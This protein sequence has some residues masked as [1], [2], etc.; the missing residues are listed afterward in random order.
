LFGDSSGIDLEQEMKDIE[1]CELR[2][3]PLFVARY[4]LSESVWPGT[5]PLGRNV[6]E[7]VG[8]LDP[9]RV[10][11]YL[12]ER[13][14]PLGAAYIKIIEREDRKDSISSKIWGFII[15]LL[16]FLSLFPIH[17]MLAPK[18]T[19]LKV[20]AG[21]FFLVT[22]ASLV[23]L[24]LIQVVIFVP[25]NYVIFPNRHFGPEHLIAVTICLI[26]SMLCLKIWSYYKMTT[27]LK[28]VHKRS[29]LRTFSSILVGDVVSILIGF[30]LADLLNTAL[31]LLNI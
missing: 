1:N 25:W 4:K 10:A 26:G 22:G 3:S 17:F 5:T 11:A 29:T 15:P 6:I 7:R 18:R 31:D 19:S 8:T 21:T 30:A 24:A 14:G 13:N 23:L 2:H 20:T 28:H 16:T 12:S 9:Q 27:Y